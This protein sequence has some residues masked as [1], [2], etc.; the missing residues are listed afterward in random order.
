MISSLE[1]KIRVLCEIMM[2][3]IDDQEMVN[4]FYYLLKQMLISNIGL[5]QILNLQPIFMPLICSNII[6][7]A[8]M[9]ATSFLL[10]LCMFN[11][12]EHVQLF[13]N[14]Q[15]QIVIHL[16]SMCRP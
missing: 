9:S 14:H 16:N 2:Q 11:D 15:T 4:L 10:D 7:Y 13:N 3:F 8:N 5:P 6:V 12:Y 1:D